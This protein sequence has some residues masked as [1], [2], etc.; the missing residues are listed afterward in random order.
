MVVY[1]SKNSNHEPDFT[2]GGHKIT[3]VSEYVYLGI[4]FPCNNNLGKSIVSLR[5]QATRAMFALIKKSR[6]LGLDIDIQLQ[7][8]DSM[9]LPITLYGCEI[10]G[11]RKLEVIEKLHLQYCKILLNVKKCTPNVMVLGELG[12][13]PLEYNVNCRMLGFW[14][15]LINGKDSKISCTLYKL[16]L[17]LHCAKTF[18]IDWIV[19]IESILRDCDMYSFWVDQDSVKEISFA[20]F[21]KLYKEKLSLVLKSKWKEAMEQ[22][23]KCSLYR[24]F[25]DELEFERYLVSVK[26]PLKS[27]MIRFRTSN[28]NLTIEL[29]R[30]VNIDREERRCTLCNTGDIGDEYNYFCICSYFDLPRKELL[31]RAIYRHPSVLKFCD[32]MKSRRKSQLVKISKLMKIIC[33]KFREV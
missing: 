26:F 28:H 7:L 21:Q 20:C 17:K 32:F 5:K 31:P 16:I 23:S 12:R 33:N 4:C 25:K 3:V 10:W 22:S 2:L 19:K 27:A 15:K 18:S 29:G 24:N 30:Y 9:V 11:F 1:G 6:Q 8:F 13:L 14:Y